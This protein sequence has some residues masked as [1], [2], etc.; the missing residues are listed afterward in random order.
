LVRNLS[1][2]GRRKLPRKNEYVIVYPE[3]VFLDENLK[4]LGIDRQR[5][6]MIGMLVGTDFNEGVKGIGP[7]KALQKVRGFSYSTFK[8]FIQQKDPSFK[9]IDVDDVFNFFLNPPCKDVEIKEGKLDEGKIFKLLV[10]EH[11]FSSERVKKAVNELKDIR[12]KSKQ[13]SL[14]EWFK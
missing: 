13:K 5:L 7:K 9:E 3:E 14:S 12:E 4:R 8:T 6:I 10:D 1:I 2:T 11:D